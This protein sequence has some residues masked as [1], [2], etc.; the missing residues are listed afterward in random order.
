MLPETL[1]L[2]TSMLSPSL[3]RLF[4]FLSGVLVIIFA[5][6]SLR[7]ADNSKTLLYTFYIF[8]IVFGILNY[9][10]LLKIFAFEN[11]KK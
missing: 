4:C 3:L 11:L 5:E 10:I 8:P 1:Q 2:I 7:S 9:L 6:I